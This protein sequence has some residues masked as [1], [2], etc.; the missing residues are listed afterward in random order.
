MSWQRAESNRLPLFAFASRY[1]PTGPFSA[2]KN[3]AI[4]TDDRSRK[5]QR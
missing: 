3:P 2:L 4:F 5:I 1:T